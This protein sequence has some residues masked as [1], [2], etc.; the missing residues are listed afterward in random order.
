MR[1]GLF[2]GTFNP[3]HACHLFIGGQTR[4]RLHLDQVLFIPS[5]DPPH[6]APASLAPI[7]H[8]YAM[9]KLAIES[10]PTFAVSD[11]ELQTATK[12][13]SIDTVRTLLAQV[14]PSA[15]LFFI[16]GLDS[17]LEFHTWRKA[18]DLLRLCPFVVVSRAGAGF[19]SLADVP[20]LPPLD[21]EA[22]ESL[23]AGRQERLDIPIPG[24]TV[25]ILLRLP[26]CPI[27]ASDIRLRVKSGQRLTPLL[28]A[29]VESYIIR[30]KLF[31]EDPDRTRL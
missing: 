26:P 13:Y 30:F 21:R 9:V 6:K 12:S 23:N 17:F 15:E 7:G 2:G 14:G 1:I 22:L 18:S 25:L 8:R 4:D 19:A 16:I 31:Q 10:D 24:G 28:P 3:I 11:V 27:S 20:L 5:G 29:S